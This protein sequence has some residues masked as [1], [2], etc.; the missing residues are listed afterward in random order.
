MVFLI[1][2]RHRPKIQGLFGAVFGITSISGPLIG[3]GFTTNV[4][5]RWCFYINLPIGAV[6]FLFVALWMKVPN[7]PTAKLP[8]VEKIQ[9]LDIFGTAVFVPCVVCL[10]LALQWGGTTY[11]VSKSYYIS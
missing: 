5:W 7:K 4:S 6:A 3:G 8:L 2:L 10:L 1:P 11:P 9:R